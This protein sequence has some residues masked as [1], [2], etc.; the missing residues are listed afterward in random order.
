MVTEDIYNKEYDVII[1]GGGVTAPA[2][3][4]IARCVD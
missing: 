2:P 1:V 4:G 3:R